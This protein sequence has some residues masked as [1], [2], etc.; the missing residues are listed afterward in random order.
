MEDGGRDGDTVIISCRGNNNAVITVQGRAAHSGENPEAGRNAG[1]ELSRQILNMLDLGDAEKYTDANWTLGS[2]GAKANIIPDTATANLNVRT[3]LNAEAD[4]VE[5]EMLKRIKTVTDPDCTVSLEFKRVRPPFEFTEKTDALAKVAEAV[6]S[7][8]LGRTLKRDR[9]GGASD[10]NFAYQKAPV[11]E[12]MG[13]GGG[14]WHALTEFLP[15]KQV[16]DRLYLLA[17]M[18]QETSRGSTVPIGTPD[19]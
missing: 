12:G 14:D 9:M 3:A 5:A 1:V 4:R 6:F 13:M 19:R 15:L 16:P 11:L 18:I 2:F 8:E 7:Q 17:R 10:A